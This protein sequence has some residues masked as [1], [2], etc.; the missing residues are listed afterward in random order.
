MHPVWPCITFQ[1][2]LPWGTEKCWLLAI[3]RTQHAVAT[4]NLNQYIYL[5]YL[6]WFISVI[7]EMKQ[8]CIILKQ[9]NR[10]LP[11][12][13]N[14]PKNGLKYCNLP[15]GAG[16]VAYHTNPPPC[17]TGIPYGYQF[18]S[19]LFHF[20]SSSLLMP[21]ESNGEWS[22]FWG[23]CTRMRDPEETPGCHVCI[24]SALAVI[25]IWEVNQQMETNHSEFFLFSSQK[26][27]FLI[28]V[29]KFK[30]GPATVA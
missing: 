23:P 25:T 1:F 2:L 28:K 14:C 6:H 15:I 13:K 29:K 21:W 17:G 3:S 27:V 22:K 5:L 12:L 26:S 19:H 20:Q 11:T 4:Q 8:Y 18:T 16:T 24:S 30:I 9:Y 10:K 7:T